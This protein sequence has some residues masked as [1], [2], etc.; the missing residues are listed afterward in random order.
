VSPDQVPYQDVPPE[1]TA[2]IEEFALAHG[3]DP[4]GEDETVVSLTAARLPWWK[5]G[6]LGRRDYRKQIRQHA[7]EQAE[8]ANSERQIASRLRDE[9]A[10]DPANGSRL[11]HSAA[12]HERRADAFQQAADHLR[13]L[14]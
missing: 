14:R 8:R 1:M 2:Y 6:P 10:T 4:P 9:A 3:L 12:M 11:L 13:K 5:R 7:D